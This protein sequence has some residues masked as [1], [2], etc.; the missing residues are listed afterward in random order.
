MVGHDLGGDG[1]PSVKACGIRRNECSQLHSGWE[2]VSGMGLE[3]IIAVP[4]NQ[5]ALGCVMAP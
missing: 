4:V 3:Q 2:F 5:G 1:F